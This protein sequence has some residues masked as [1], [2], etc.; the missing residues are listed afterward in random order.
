[1]T[2]QYPYLEEED[3][4][5]GKAFRLSEDEVLQMFGGLGAYTS[6]RLD[7]AKAQGNGYGIPEL[8][9]TIESQIQ[10]LKFAEVTEKQLAA[11]LVR[12]QREKVGGIMSLLK[13]NSKMKAAE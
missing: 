6:H 3:A 13:V 7:R 1:M 9:R 2:E 4:R 12:Q 11:E 5:F 8:P 10:S